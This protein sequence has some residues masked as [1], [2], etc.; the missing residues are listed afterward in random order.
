VRS[1]MRPF[2]PAVV[3]L[4]GAALFLAAC[5]SSTGTARA[6]VPA[7]GLGVGFTRGSYR[8]AMTANEGSYRGG[9][10]PVADRLDA[11]VTL[12]GAEQT[13]KIETRGI[14]GRYF[15]RLTGTPLPDL[16]GNWYSVD[17]SRVHN[18]GSLGISAAKD[19]TGIRALVAAVTSV[20][21]RGGGSYRGLADLRKVANW[22][23]VTSGQIRQMGDAARTTHFEAA[24]DSSG[25]L[26]SMRV[27]VPGFLNT[28][29]N[30]VTATYSDFGAE[31][32]VALPQGAAPLPDSLYALL[33]L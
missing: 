29:P 24:L 18:A 10:D 17:L 23:P 2:R 8:F 30:V 12:K 20:Q 9:I 28:P 25:R 27:W 13:L 14:R 32:P 33:N 7:D 15:A 31:V 6:L 3:A 11:I 4:V 21:G 5:A 1:R 22:G 19:P 16:E 26:T